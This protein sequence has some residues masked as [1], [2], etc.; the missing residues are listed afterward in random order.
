MAK[1]N[2]FRFS[3]KYQDDETDLLYY[4]YRYYN[5][6][7]GRWL[8]RD[9]AEQRGAGSLYCFVKNEPCGAFDR[10]GRISVSVVTTKPSTCC[11]SANDV[12]FVFV[13]DKPAAEDGYIVQENIADIPWD[14]CDAIVHGNIWTDHYWEAWFVPAN[15]TGPASD[16]VRWPGKNKT[17]GAGGV[18]GTIKF[19][20]KSH[21]GVD[22]LKDW[23]TKISSPSSLD[24]PS[25]RA[26]PDWWSDPS[27]NGERDAT[28]SVHTT[29]DCCCP[30]N[31]SFISVSPGGITGVGRGPCD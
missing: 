16:Q 2:P 17:S 27:D 10:D 13:L 12:E 25:T 6:S 24:L 9:P 8:S 11:G 14:T 5:A 30:A 4:G 23:T 3:T 29:W 7:S 28:R 1:A 18:D 31:I 19:F 22:D 20:F 21:Q 26:R 15:S